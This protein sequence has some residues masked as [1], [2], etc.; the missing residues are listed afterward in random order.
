MTTMWLFPYWEMV[1]V[2]GTIPEEKTAKAA[3]HNS[4]IRPWIIERAIA[5]CGDGVVDENAGVYGRF[6]I[7]GNVSVHRIGDGVESIVCRCRTILIHRGKME[8]D[9]Y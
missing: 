6:C 8:Y 2:T 3:P 5:A 1:Q 9:Y 4:D 7:V